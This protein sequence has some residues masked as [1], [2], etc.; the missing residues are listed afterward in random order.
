MNRKNAILSAACFVVVY[1]LLYFAPIVA[2]YSTKH[3][4][5]PVDNFCFAFPQLMFPF[6]IIF[7]N[8]HSLN[9]YIAFLI[10][11][12]YLIFLGW[13]FSLSTRSIQKFRWIV[14]LAFCFSIASVIALNLILSALSIFGISVEPRMP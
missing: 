13:L 3:I 5:Y 6:N 9:S 7:W 4:P 8:Y 10:S 2:I 11:A 14:L 12:L 1:L